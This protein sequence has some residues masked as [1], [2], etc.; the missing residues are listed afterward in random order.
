MEKAK[1]TIGVDVSRN[2][3]DIYCIEVKRHIQISNNTAGFILFRSFCKQHNIALHEAIVVLEYT[4]GYEYKWLQF[5]QSKN[6]AYV[7][8]PGLAI[9]RSLGIVRGKNDKI[10]AAR[11]AQYGDEKYKS[12]CAEKPV[13]T[14]ILKLKDLLGFRK[15]LVRENAG[16][17]AQIKERMHMYEVGKDD[18]IIRT[19]N[20][21]LHS[22]IK[23][24][25]ATEKLL[26]QQVQSD[27]E[28]LNNFLLL[29][30]IKG[31]GNINALMTIVFTE[32]FSSF[33]SARSYAVYVGV[34]PFD[35]SSGTSLKGKKRVSPI[36]NKE[37]KQEL[38]QAARA[39]IQYDKELQEYAVRKLQT[40]P[41][42][43]V[44]NNVKFKLILR[45]FSV[46]KRGEKYVDK[47]ESAA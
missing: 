38:N 42:G 46:V 5:C 8:I 30:S 29:K 16:Y 27:K 37:L 3:L 15:K 33:T 28:I 26:L 23:E 40:K 45:M 39:S 36:A 21:K 1:F 19:L 35:Y 12:I 25:A 13:N 11:I 34:I 20:K 14:S 22:N 43:I 4:G 10:D 47:Y 24:I 32:N 17:K 6:I 44:L 31:I 9:K 2:T 41:Y 18:F 7:R